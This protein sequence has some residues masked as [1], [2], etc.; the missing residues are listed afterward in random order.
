MERVDVDGVPV[1]WAEAPGPLAASLTFRVG[2][3]DETFVRM[4][5][6]HLVEHLAMSKLAKRH[7]SYNASVDVSRTIFT[8]SGRPE[9]V[10]AFL[11]DLC[12]SLRELPIDRLPTEVRVLKAEGG[13]V[14]HPILCEHLRI[15]FGARGIGLAGYEEPALDQI[16]PAAV[17]D[18]AARHFVRENAV[19][20][21]TGAPPEGLAL[22]LPIGCR[23]VRERPVMLPAPYPMYTVQ[24][25]PGFGA[26]FECV[27]DEA[28]NA[29]LRIAADR[30]FD[31]LRHHSGLL[32]EFDFAAAEY[33]DGDALACFFGNPPDEN[34]AEVW[35]RFEAVLRELASHGPTDAELAH[36]LDGLRE[37]LA[38]PR[39][40]QSMLDD[41]AFALLAD[42][43]WKDPAGILAER[44]QVRGEDVMAALAGYQRSVLLTVPETADDGF[45]GLRREPEWSPGLIEGRRF[46]RRMLR[47]PLPRGSSIIIGAEGLSLD[48]PDRPVTIRWA[49]VVGAGIDPDGVWTLYSV[50]N[51][52][53]PVHEAWLKD[54]DQA[55]ALMDAQV[56]TRLRFAETNLADS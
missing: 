47:S 43:P 42:R 37:S 25:G 39:S 5:I 17:L 31:E 40:V 12:A 49:D 7:L 45:S 52:S 28:A 19:L 6:T 14:D 53:L 44:E 41:A 18:W 29:A 27:A 26:S 38:D 51:M 10:V 33:A 15:R 55:M 48:L 11:A 46:A 36:D 13:A 22:P 50:D 2:L 20:C 9:F 34:V 30:A 3:R 4:G 1:L 24:H 23:N 54:G 56:P 21:L 32:Y 8:A 16:P 35:R